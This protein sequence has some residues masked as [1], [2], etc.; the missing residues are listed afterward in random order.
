MKQKLLTLV[1]CSLLAIWTVSAKDIASG[2]FKNG[3]IYNVQGVR[4]R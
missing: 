2:T 1:A 3:A 4:V